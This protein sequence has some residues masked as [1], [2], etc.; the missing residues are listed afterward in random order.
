V[1]TGADGFLFGRASDV[2][3]NIEGMHD[4]VGSPA[5]LLIDEAKTIRNEILDTLDVA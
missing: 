3:G 2:S 4:Q 5:A 1:R